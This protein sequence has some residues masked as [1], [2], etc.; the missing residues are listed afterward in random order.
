MVSTETPDH[1]R[2]EASMAPL[3]RFKKAAVGGTLALTIAGAFVLYPYDVP[4]AKGFVL[5]SVAGVAGFWSLAQRLEKLASTGMNK[6]QSAAFRWAL[7]RMVIY[8]LALGWAYS[9]DPD[10]MYALLAGV[11][12]LFSIRVVLIFLALTGLDLNR[13]PQSQ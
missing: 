2:H 1:D 13:K 7:L 10:R 5:G 9:L 3:R 12:G 6:V 4:V 11:I 8:A